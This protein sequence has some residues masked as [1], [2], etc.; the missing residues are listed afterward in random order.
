M[1]LEDCRFMQVMDSSAEMVNGR[2]QLPLP[3]KE[4]IL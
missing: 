3:F 1:S 4:I 2:Y